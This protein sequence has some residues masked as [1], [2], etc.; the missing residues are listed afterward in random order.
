LIARLT[1][2]KPSVNFSPLD[3]LN[4]CRI[5]W[6]RDSPHPLSLTSSRGGVNSETSRYAKAIPQHI[7]T[8]I[9]HLS[10]RNPAR[11]NARST[12]Y[13]RPKPGILVSKLFRYKT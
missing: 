11:P 10:L 6:S 2:S 7:G 13:R 12:M 3:M 4:M 5:F 9:N 1:R 8:G